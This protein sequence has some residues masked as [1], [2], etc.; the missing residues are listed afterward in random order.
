MKKTASGLQ[1]ECVNKINPE[2]NN[3]D[4]SIATCHID[5]YGCIFVD[6]ESES[7]IDNE[8]DLEEIAL[9]MGL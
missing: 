5:N 7:P 4:V 9:E 1:Y 8:F 3:Y 6:A 2:W